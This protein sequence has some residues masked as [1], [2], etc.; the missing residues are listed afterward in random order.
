M[1]NFV[2]FF[3]ELMSIAVFGGIIVSMA[4]IYTLA[5]P[6]DV[7]SIKIKGFINKNILTIGFLVAV[8]AMGI[9]LIYSN[10]IGYPP[11]LLCW[12]A[13]VMFYPQVFL[14]G[15]ALIKKDRSILPYATILTGLGLIIT[16]YHSII[17]L[18]G[19][20]L[21]PCTVSGV[22]CLT[23]YVFM[24]GFIT[25]PFMGFIGFCVQFLS[26]LISRKNKISH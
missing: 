18:V 17:M 5:I 15:Y 10:V 16:L 22:S 4:L 2:N 26:L 11:C 20:S 6:N 25:I 14:F 1:Q 12:W 23:R 8:M 9:S 3:N 7:F 13:R 21:V 19:E 24:F